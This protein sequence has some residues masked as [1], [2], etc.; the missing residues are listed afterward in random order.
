MFVKFVVSSKSM[1][2]DDPWK[3][4][5]YNYKNYINSKSKSNYRDKL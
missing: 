4:I 5:N 1:Q 3:K 2:T